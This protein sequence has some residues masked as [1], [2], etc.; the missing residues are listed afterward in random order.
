MAAHR[1]FLFK[2]CLGLWLPGVQHSE[3]RLYS[4]RHGIHMFDTLSELYVILVKYFYFLFSF[5]NSKNRK[6]VEIQLKVMS[7]LFLFTLERDIFPESLL[8]NCGW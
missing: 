2:D 7:Y 6:E 4:D 5:S 3:L 8:I 1:F